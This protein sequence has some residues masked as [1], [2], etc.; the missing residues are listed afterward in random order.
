MKNTQDGYGI[1]SLPDVQHHH[2]SLSPKQWKDHNE[3]CTR[4]HSN[5]TPKLQNPMP[6]EK[7][8]PPPPIATIPILSRLPIAK[9]RPGVFLVWHPMR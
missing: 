9:H 6:P 4:D 8:N 2:A 5:T 7:A 3:D 1:R